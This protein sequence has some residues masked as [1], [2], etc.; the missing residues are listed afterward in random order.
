MSKQR[1]RIFVYADT[2][3]LSLIEK[4]SKSNTVSGFTANPTILQRDKEFTGKART[5]TEFAQEAIK[6][7]GSL[8]VSLPT[9]GDT[10]GELERQAKLL[11]SWGDQV[12]VKL[13][14]V[15]R[16]G[17]PTA[18]LAKRLSRS[19]I[20]LNITAVMSLRQVRIAAEAVGGGAPAIISVFAGRIA[21][22]GRD[23]VPIMA[24][25]AEMVRSYSNIQLLWASPRE[26]LNVVQAD[27]CGCHIITLPPAMI[28]RTV[29]WGKDLEQYSRETVEQFDRDAEKAGLVL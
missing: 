26:L 5:F 16:T 25:A 2:A 9:Y 3:D 14:V 8:T 11:A 22:T 20:A 21:D 28:E 24:A 29:L 6:L 10:F 17:E 27:N 1:L 23:P 18:T 4:Y 12:R 13:P 7:A 19:G 15:T